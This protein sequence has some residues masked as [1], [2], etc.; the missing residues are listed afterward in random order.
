VT[1]APA[2][3]LAVLMTLLAAAPVRARGQGSPRAARSVSG[4]TLRADSIAFA[5]L[6]APLHELLDVRAGIQPGHGD[7]GVTCVPLST[8]ADGSRR[9]RLQGRLADGSSLVTFARV[10]GHGT[11]ARVEFVRRLPS[12]EQRGFTWDLADDATTG[13]D[14]AVGSTAAVTYP[15]PRG[16]PVPR[17]VRALGRIVATWNCAGDGAVR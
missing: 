2:L 9:L 4:D 13:A 7:P 5:A 3:A 14:W 15:V 1:V 16:G 17:A 8:T 6:P 10:T 12:G 11:L